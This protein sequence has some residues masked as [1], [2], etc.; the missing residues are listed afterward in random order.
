MKKIILG[1]AILICVLVGTISSEAITKVGAKGECDTTLSGC[2]YYPVTPTILCQAPEFCT[3]VMAPDWSD[4]NSNRFYG[5]DGANCRKSI[6]GGDT[7]AN[8]G[9][10]PSATAY[11]Q[12]AVTDLGTVLAGA[13]DG[14]GTVFR[15]R[16]ST[17]GAVTWNTV[18]DGTPIDTL[19]ATITNGRFRCGQFSGVCAFYGR[20]ASNSMW[21]LVSVNDGVTWTL[22]TGIGTNIFNYI[23]TAWS[24]EGD[25]GIGAVSAGDGFSTIRTMEWNGADYSRNATNFP[26]TA[27]GQC[28]WAFILDGL[29]RSICHETTLGTTYTMRSEDGT[30]QKTFSLPDVPSDNGGTQVGLAYSVATNWIGLLRTDTLGR[31]GI[32]ISIDSATSFIKILATDPVGQGIGSQGSV[33]KGVNNC[34]Y[35]SYVTTGAAS[36]VGKI[37]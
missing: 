7:W 16:R 18:Y 19:N 20:D 8:C 9:S 22:T 4:T 2:L 36:T 13:N 15:I 27:G 17:D 23:N 29:R 37:C 11:F 5:S 1:L 14:G 6:D 35:F 34:M 28:N 3:R 24:S 31:T 10:N 32:W 33:F 25:I 26:T 12:Y 21:S 30:V